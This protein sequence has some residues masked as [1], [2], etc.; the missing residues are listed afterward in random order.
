MRGEWIST[1]TP[2][3]LN[4]KQNLSPIQILARYWSRHYDKLNTDTVRGEFQPV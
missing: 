4:K 3:P 1:L 2:E